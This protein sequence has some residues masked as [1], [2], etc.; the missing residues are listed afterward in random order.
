[1]PLQLGDRLPD[2]A[3]VDHEGQPWRPADFR[4]RPVVLV[5]HRHLA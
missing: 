5:L 4:G 3:L 2:I 1:M